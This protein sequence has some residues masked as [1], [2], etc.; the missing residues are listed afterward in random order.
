[1]NK[2]SRI[3]LYSLGGLAAIGLILVLRTKPV[4]AKGAQIFVTP[5]TLVMAIPEDD[6]PCNE[7][8]GALLWGAVPLRKFAG[9]LGVTP[10]DMLAL[11]DELRNS[12]LQHNP[13][14]LYLFGHGWHWLYTAE[15]CEV[16]IN[17][18]TGLNMDLVPGRIVHLLS[19]LTARELGY[20]TI[21]E[22]AKAYF[23][24]FESYWLV[25]KVRPGAGR[26]CEAALY[27]D[28]EIEVLLHEGIRDLK[29]LYDGA[30]Q[31]FNDEITYWEENWQDESVNGVAITEN[32]A[33]MLIDVLII[34][35]DAL[36]CYF[37]VTEEYPQVGEYPAVEEQLEHYLSLL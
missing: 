13:E 31:R 32:D 34:N 20:A 11:P 3:A 17:A 35:R 2:E 5:E 27:G 1:M 37:P 24:Y 18:Q 19:C 4:E 22:G 26:F 14:R 6:S 33:Q 21:E 25:G 12:I 23:G 10:V 8:G 9:E 28:M 36:R 16:V 7:N 15:R 29:E 30:V